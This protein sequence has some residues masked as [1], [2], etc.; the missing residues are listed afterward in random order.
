MTETYW[1][2]EDDT[3]YRMSGSEYTHAELVAALEAEAAGLDPA[4]WVY[5]YFNVRDYIIEATNVGLIEVVLP[6]EG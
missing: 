3:I 6:D 4:Q 5:G 2:D 1:L